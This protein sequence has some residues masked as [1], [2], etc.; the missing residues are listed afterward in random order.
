MS[1][2]GGAHDLLG[3]LVV[4]LLQPKNRTAPRGAPLQQFRTSPGMEYGGGRRGE[5][6]SISRAVGH[7]GIGQRV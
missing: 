4:C 7:I 6:G 1:A 2:A 5:I 3:L